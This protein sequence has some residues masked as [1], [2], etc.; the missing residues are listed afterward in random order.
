MKTKLSFFF[1]ILFIFST[2]LLFGQSQ[3]SKYIILG[4]VQGFQNGTKMYLNDVSDGSY[5]K[6]DSTKIINGKFTFKGQLKTKFL[7]SSISTGDYSERVT[8][9]LEKGL[10]SFSA[11]KGNFKK[12]EIKGSKI[13]EKYRELLKLQD[14]LEKTDHIDY[15]FI[16]QNPTSVIAAH[17]L[18]FY[19]NHWGKDTI[20]ALYHSFSKDVKQ[21]RYGK[22]IS[23]FLT[24]NRN[25]KIGDK[26]VD[27][28]QKDTLGNLIKLSDIK[29]KYMLLEFWGS[30]CGPCRE[31]NPSLVKIYNEFKD[32]GF[33]IF[34][35]ASE[36]NKQQWINA[37]QTDGLNWINVTDLKGDS[38]QAAIIYGVSGYPTNFLI[39]KDGIIIAK[40][41]YGEDLRNWLLKI[42]K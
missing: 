27:F 12:A 5:K 33:E 34:G 17:T 41:V 39:N 10:N 28:S 30:W 29:E 26:M 19:C 4:Q 23:T 1:G 42:L 38:N 7:K 2:T 20:S 15:S 11:H 24:L 16:K 37:I 3:Q 36:T 6:I 13:Q 35:V 32:K 31:E 14:T 8:F 22:K 9:W 21:S 40:D 18:S 25:I